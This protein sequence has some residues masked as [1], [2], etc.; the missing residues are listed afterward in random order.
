M[1]APQTN[2]ERQKRRHAG[3]I[4]G[5]VVVVAFALGL[6]FAFI[7]FLSSNGQPE[8]SP[9]SQGIAIPADTN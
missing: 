9:T 4:I 7:T 8:E 6:L 2:I 1:S 5:M 3:P